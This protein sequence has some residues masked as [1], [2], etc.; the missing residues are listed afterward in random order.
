[1]L[2]V[3][4]F[5]KFTLDNDR[6]MKM[7]KKSSWNRV[8]TDTLTPLFSEIIRKIFHSHIKDFLT[9]YTTK[10]QIFVKVKE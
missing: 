6:I 2:C 5:S 3:Q 1:M 7:P 9:T 4:A 10:N 8:K